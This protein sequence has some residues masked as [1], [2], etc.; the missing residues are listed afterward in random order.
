M[1]GTRRGGD[2]GDEEETKS[3]EFKSV[4]TKVQGWIGWVYVGTGWASMVQFNVAYAF[5]PPH[6]RSRYG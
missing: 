6:I 3:E 1:E 4:L 5:E 2:G